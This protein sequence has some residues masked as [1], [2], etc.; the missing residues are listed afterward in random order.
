MAAFKRGDRVEVEHNGRDYPATIASVGPSGFGVKYQNGTAEDDVEIERIRKVTT[1]PKA[2]AKAKAK[3]KKPAATKSS[4]AKR[5]AA[6]K[7]KA[8]RI[9]PGP[10]KEFKELYLRFLNNRQRTRV[11]MH[12]ET[13]LTVEQGLQVDGKGV[14]PAPL[15]HTFAVTKSGNAYRHLDTGTQQ[16]G[17]VVRNL[18]GI[19]SGE[20]GTAQQFQLALMICLYGMM[21]YNKEVMAA[22]FFTPLRKKPVPLSEA[23]PATWDEQKKLKDW[24]RGQKM[25]K[26]LWKGSG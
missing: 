25:R 3:A 9:A 26:G 5:P 17:A 8:A 4:A 16:F 7:A 11:G 24:A 22:E 21:G 15:D 1:T 18:L 23:L 20:A 14:E 13:V 6:K 12:S 2:K 19:S 10:N